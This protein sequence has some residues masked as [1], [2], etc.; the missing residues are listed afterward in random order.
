M[1]VPEVRTPHPTNTL[2]R[3]LRIH[4]LPLRQERARILF[5]GKVELVPGAHPGGPGDDREL[6]SPLALEIEVADVQ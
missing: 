4:P 1:F 6:Q 2:T 5:L 3:L